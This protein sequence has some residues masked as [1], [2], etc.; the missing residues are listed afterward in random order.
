MARTR[1]RAQIGEVGDR[2]Q[3]RVQ[4][5]LG[6]MPLQSRLRRDEGMPIG[7]CGRVAEHLL[8]VRAEN[9]DDRGVELATAPFPGDL[10]R[11]IDAAGA[12][13]DLDHVRDVEEPG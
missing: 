9:V 11:G 7:F 12:V 2:L 1:R 5:P 8:G 13:E 10:Q 4:L 3:R 6:E